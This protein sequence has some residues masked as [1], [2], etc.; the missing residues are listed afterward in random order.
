M[1]SLLG[2]LEYL[3]LDYGDVLGA[4]GNRYLDRGPGADRGGGPVMPE[5]GAA[6][7]AEDECRAAARRCGS[8]VR[9]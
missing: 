1:V 6:A 2:Y 7:Q 9:R 3:R 4:E 5:P 8:R